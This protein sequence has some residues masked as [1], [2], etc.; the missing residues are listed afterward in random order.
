MTGSTTP[1]VSGEP[2]KGFVTG[3]TCCFLSWLRSLLPQGLGS[4]KLTVVP[5]LP[6]LTVREMVANS[7]E[8]FITVG[9]TR[10]GSREIQFFDGGRC[11]VLMK[12]VPW[13]VAK[14]LCSKFPHS[15]P[16][17]LATLLSRNELVLGGLQG[18]SENS[19][20]ELHTPLQ[21]HLY[22]LSLSLAL[23]R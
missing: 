2:K 18:L 22:L 23:S 6:L 19:R 10:R 13:E 12:G 3:G 20:T 8:R 15:F 16:K 4:K 17:S 11:E 9:T 1:E 7:F 21:L 14:Q 5:T